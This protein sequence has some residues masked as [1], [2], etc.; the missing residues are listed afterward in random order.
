MQNDGEL[1]TWFLDLLPEIRN[2]FYDI[3]F[4]IEGPVTLAHGVDPARVNANPTRDD[5]QTHSQLSD[6]RDGTFPYLIEG[7]NLLAAC[8]QIHRKATPMLY[9]RNESA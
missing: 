7:V 1:H 8:H 9:S 3:L 2:A 6:P 5:G 4:Q